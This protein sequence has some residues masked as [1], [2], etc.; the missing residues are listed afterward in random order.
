MTFIPGNQEIREFLEHGFHSVNV[1][2]FSA[3]LSG[4]QSRA[5]FL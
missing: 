1:D 4:I 2:K 3:W 5:V